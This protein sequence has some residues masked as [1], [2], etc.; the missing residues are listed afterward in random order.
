MNG[1][2]C[3]GADLGNVQG[4]IDGHVRLSPEDYHLRSQVI[5]YASSLV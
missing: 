5:I 2:G 1:L 3:L 4:L